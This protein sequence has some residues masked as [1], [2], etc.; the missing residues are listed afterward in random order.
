MIVAL[1]WSLVLLLVILLAVLLAA[2]HRVTCTATT[3]EE[4]DGWLL[5]GSYAVPASL[6]TVGAVVGV[7]LAWWV[8]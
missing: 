3:L 2:D 1:F 7:G 8:R 4:I 5:V 6:L